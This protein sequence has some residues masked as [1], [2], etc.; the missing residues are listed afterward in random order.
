VWRHSA[1]NPHYILTTSPPR[2][3]RPAPL[4]HVPAA[5]AALVELV[6]LGWPGPPPALALPLAPPALLSKTRAAGTREAIPDDSA[7]RRRS[8]TERKSSGWAPASCKFL[9]VAY[10][11]ESSDESACLF[12]AAAISDDCKTMASKAGSSTRRFLLPE[13]ICRVPCCKPEG[14]SPST[15]AA[16]MW[17]LMS[18]NIRWCLLKRV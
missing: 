14:A 10:K 13:E 7:S 6:I 1:W 18:F 3:H 17:G 5:T 16:P 12:A 15:P 2:R 9:R 8:S 4:P 11:D